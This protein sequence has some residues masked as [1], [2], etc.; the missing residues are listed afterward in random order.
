MFIRHIQL[1]S[2]GKCLLIVDG[3]KGKLSIYMQALK[4]LGEAIARCASSK[5]LQTERVGHCPLF[6]FD[7]AKRM[8]AVCS[9]VKVPCPVVYVTSVAD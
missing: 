5:E 9:D 1:L 8:L 3:G 6:A 4:H 2:A 7:E